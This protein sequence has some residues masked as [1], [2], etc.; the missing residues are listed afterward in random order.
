LVDARR[1]SPFDN[2][3]RREVL[4]VEE[5]SDADLDAIGRAR[6]PAEYAY[7]NAELDE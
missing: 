6:V 2:E 7:L 1:P 4:L 3:H 5:L